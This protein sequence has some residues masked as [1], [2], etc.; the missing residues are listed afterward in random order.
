MEISIILQF[1]DLFQIIIWK[2]SMDFLAD[3]SE[4]KLVLDIEVSKSL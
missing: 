1:L 3:I 2:G 4:S